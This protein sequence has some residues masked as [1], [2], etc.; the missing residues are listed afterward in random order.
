M[1]QVCY[2]KSEAADEGDEDTTQPISHKDKEKIEKE[3]E[4]IRAHKLETC[5]HILIDRM[6]KDA[7]ILIYEYIYIII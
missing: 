6:Q 5:K 7:V 4:T 3:K 1:L 2:I